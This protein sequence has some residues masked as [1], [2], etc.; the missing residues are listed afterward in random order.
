M[1]LVRRG[2]I[3]ITYFQK[4]KKTL[5]LVSDL[6]CWVL[7]NICYFS[8]KIHFIH[9]NLTYIQSHPNADLH[10]DI[11]W[12]SLGYITL[13]IDITCFTQY[14]FIYILLNVI[15]NFTLKSKQFRSVFKIYMISIHIYNIYRLPSGGSQSFLLKYLS[16]M[17]VIRFCQWMYFME[18]NGLNWIR[19]IEKK[20]NTRIYTFS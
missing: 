18:G 3:N 20:E 6:Y 17:C 11:I 8:I 15:W 14:S 16:H 13:I 4:P 1:I 19:T 12:Y 9:K 10:N 7:S 5:W 2:P